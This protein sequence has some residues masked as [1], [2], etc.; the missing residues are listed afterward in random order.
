MDNLKFY[1]GPVRVPFLVLAPACVFLG[2]GTS[3]WTSGHIS[4]LYSGLAFLGGLCAHISVNSFNE[5]FDFKSGLDSKTEKTPFSGGS[6]TL[7]KKPELASMALGIAVTTFVITALVGIFFMKVWGLKILPLGVLGLLTVFAYTPLL[8]KS[9]VFCLVAPG[10]GFGTFMVM[11]TDFV[12]TG[13]YSWT[14][15]IAS[16]VPFFLVSNLLLLN[17]FPDVEADRS[18]GRKHFPITIG[19][20]KSGIIFSL[21]YLFAYLSIITG[22]VFHYLPPKSLLGLGTVF[23]A[24]P[25]AVGAVKN[26]DD[27]A[28][29]AP[30]MGMNV[31]INLLTPVLFSAGL[32]LSR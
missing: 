20:R 16:L 32:I 7:Q 4:I 27:I 24:V 12:L 1:L 22:V 8:T 9:P 29:L 23:L 2:C 25:A 19:R 28:R 18:T 26:A 10:L 5:Y 11:G 6:G 21:F 15:F 30:F 31:I 14:S 13:H 3:I 17:Q